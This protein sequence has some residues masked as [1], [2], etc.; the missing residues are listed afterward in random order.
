MSS[1]M[2]LFPHPQPDI[3]EWNVALKHQ[4]NVGPCFL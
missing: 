4:N 1:L 3:L 2:D